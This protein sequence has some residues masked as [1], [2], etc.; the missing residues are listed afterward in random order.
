MKFLHMYKLWFSLS[1]LILLASIG[2]LSAGGLK[3]GIDFTGGS[4]LEV[5]FTGDLP[6]GED[7]VSSL[8][9]LN[10]GDVQVQQSGEKTMFL[11]MKDIDNTSRQ[12]ILDR[13]KEKYGE[14]TE[15]HFES[16][17]PTIGK[18]LQERSLQAIGLV[19]LGIIIYVSWAFRQVSKGPVPSWVYGVCAILAL[20]HD[21]LGTT[22]VF[23][24]LGYFYNIEVGALFVTALLTILGFSVHDTIVVYDRIRETIQ[25]HSGESF[26]TIL[27][28]S[29]ESTVVRSLNTSVTTILVLFVLF[30]FGGESIRY[31][32]LALMIGITLGTYSSIFIASPLLL[33]WEKLRHRKEA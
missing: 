19:L 31:F 13:L 12:Q 27:R 11:R 26:R 23:A 30:L 2:F 24:A 33:F 32:V 28:H 22:G 8:S 9:D 29:M 6:K 3:L 25:K 5:R 14:V 21:I 15:E 17:G 4:L 18:E 1:M 20:V 10:L 16:V 7:V